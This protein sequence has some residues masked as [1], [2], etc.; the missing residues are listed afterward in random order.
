VEA[1]DFQGAVSCLLKELKHRIRRVGGSDITQLEDLAN[2]EVATLPGASALRLTDGE[3]VAHTAPSLP[4]HRLAFVAPPFPHTILVTTLDASP[5][6]PAQLAPILWWTACVRVRLRP[7]ERADLHAI[8]LLPEANS[9]STEWRSLL[10]TDERFCRKLAWIV[11]TSKK[12]RASS[13]EVFLDRTFL[14]QPWAEDS[15]IGARGLDPLAD[16]ADSLTGTVPFSAATVHAW[17][18]LLGRGSAKGRDLAEEL[19]RIAEE[20][21]GS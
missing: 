13:V 18:S 19:V 5:R 7:E 12:G 16:L 11:P 21:R 4:E 2:D 9:S 8:V 20:S 1:S 17:L 10:E 3:A 15:R 14:A 6:D